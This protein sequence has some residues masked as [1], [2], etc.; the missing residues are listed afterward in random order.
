MLYNVQGMSA[1][2]SLSD[3][4]FQLSMFEPAH[5]LMD[6]G[7]GSFN[8]GDLGIEEATPSTHGGYRERRQTPAEGWEQKL[9]EADYDGLYDSI[10]KRG[11]T[12]P[13]ALLA[14]DLHERRW[15][16]F[17]PAGNIMD[18]H[19]RIAAANEIDPNMEVPVTWRGE[20]KFG[21]RG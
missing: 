6:G 11:V 2:R 17:L 18:G 20:R 16:R 3:K 8:P 9:E 12:K 13:V 7:I 14:V 4:Q 5:K 10:A 19:H 21:D 15:K 1:Q